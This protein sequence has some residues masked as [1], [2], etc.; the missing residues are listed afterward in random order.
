MTES[1]KDSQPVHPFST[2]TVWMTETFGDYVKE[3]QD[4]GEK[5]FQEKK[6]T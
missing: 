3:R 4:R 1:I 2:W 6:S 5:K